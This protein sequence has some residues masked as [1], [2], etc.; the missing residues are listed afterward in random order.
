MRI[1]SLLVWLIWNW[2]SWTFLFL[3]VEVVH[4]PGFFAQAELHL[5]LFEYFQEIFEFQFRPVLEFIIITVRIVPAIPVLLIATYHR[6]RLSDLL[7]TG[8]DNPGFA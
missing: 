2:R 8:L 7:Q 5:L 1:I 6:A 4:S 3:P